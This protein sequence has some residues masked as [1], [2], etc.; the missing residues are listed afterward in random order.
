M[1][2]QLC[3]DGDAADVER[4]PCGC[5]GGFSVAAWGEKGRFPIFSFKRP[6]AID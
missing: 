2:Q 3:L 5:E 4:Y 1:M 6:D